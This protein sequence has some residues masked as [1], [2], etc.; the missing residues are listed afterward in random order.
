[1]AHSGRHGRTSLTVPA[2]IQL[3]T[4]DFRC[5]QYVK[6]RTAGYGIFDAP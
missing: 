2:V 1:M 5:A 4:S 3:A 6:Q